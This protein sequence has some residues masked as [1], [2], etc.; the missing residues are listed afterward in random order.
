MSMRARVFLLAIAACLSAGVAAAQAALTIPDG[1]LVVQ[2]STN[3]VQRQI[4]L[5]ADSGV[6][7]VSLSM[8]WE[9]M[10]PTPD[11]Y[12]APGTPGAEALTQLRQRLQ[13]ARSRNLKVE[14]RL[15]NAPAWAS[16]REGSDDPPLPR[17]LP[18]YASFL[19]DLASELGPLID[20]Y[21]PW[22]EPNRPA[23]WSPTNADA[24]TALQAAAYP[25]IKEGDPTA[26]VLYGPV[27][28][29]FAARNSGYTFLRRT[30]Q[31]GGRG[32]FDAIGWN[33][34]PGGPPESSAPIED[35]VPAGNT[36]PGQIYLRGLIDSFDPGRK[37]WLMEFGWSTCND[38]DVSRANSVSEVT[39]ADY[40]QRAFDF[41]R[42]YLSDSVERIFWYELRDGGADR[43]SWEQNHG[44]LR[45]DYTLK[46][47]FAAL[48]SLVREVGGG[49]RAA[50]PLP[51]AAT[52]APAAAIRLGIPPAARSV[53]GGRTSIGPLRVR[54]KNRV[55]RVTTRIAVR[56]GSIR[57]VAEGY[58]GRKW[59]TLK[60][61]ST[62]RS[63][64]LALRVRDLGY[65]A[66]RVRATVPGTRGLRVGRVV[67]VPPRLLRVS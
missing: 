12:K 50:D 30:Y 56:G 65:V 34:Y 3:D 38:C 37:V 66:F 23:F 48:R 32:T 42:R 35:G 11:G 44:L 36:L 29:R 1:G 63:G 4:D 28:G 45:H 47:A 58:R 52:P 54:L 51:G 41:R 7:W 19:R 10:E 5:A 14:L 8:A 17:H 22:N 26:T 16:G 6:P 39:Q 24:F 61:V 49:M 25:A 57:I 60:I 55:F 62:T 27:V 21:S 43:R 40:L 46:P 33:G 64:A 18:D 13:Y 59:R 53:R 20:A 9:A 2:G 31:L 15:V 67:R